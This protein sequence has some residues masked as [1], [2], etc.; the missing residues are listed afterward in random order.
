MRHQLDAL[1]VH[2]EIHNLLVSL[3]GANADGATASAPTT[4]EAMQLLHSRGV[5]GQIVR[6]LAP[7]AKSVEAAVK[8]MQAGLDAPPS[9]TG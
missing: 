7:P 3:S 6:S 1:N 5:V 2:Q 9:L 8:S 4:E